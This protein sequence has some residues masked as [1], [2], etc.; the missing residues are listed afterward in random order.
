MA[1]VFSLTGLWQHGIFKFTVAEEL[2][3][4]VDQRG[5]PIAKP[6]EY[7]IKFKFL[8][9]SRNRQQLTTLEQGDILK[10]QYNCR[11]V[12]VD[13]NEEKPELPKS[14]KPGDVGVGSL[15]DRPC[16]ATVIDISQ[17][18]VVDVTLPAL[19]E[20]VRLELDYSIG[21]GSTG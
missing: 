13:G 12:S 21:R 14:I 10:P 16:R 11:V 17:A 3:G 19:G 6:R 7:D 1:T 4:E 9:Q 20:F 5:N 8:P 18:S 15:R 2:T